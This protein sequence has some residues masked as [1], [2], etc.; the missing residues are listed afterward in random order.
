MAGSASTPLEA[1]RPLPSP[2]QYEC[3]L[4]TGL[5]GTRRH[6]API[7]CRP[8]QGGGASS[9]INSGGLADSRLAYW[10]RLLI[11]FVLTSA[12]E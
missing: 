11:V 2:A 9:T 10:T 7:R 12:K 8:R 6:F 4:R 1:A 3:T 5:E